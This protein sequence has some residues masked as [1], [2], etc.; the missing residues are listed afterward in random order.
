MNL[1]EAIVEHEPVVAP[2]LGNILCVI[3]SL[4]GCDDT[5]SCIRSIVDQKQTGFDLLVVD[6][7]SLPGTVENITAAHPSVEVVKL[8]EN[9]GW[10]GGNN[11]GIK[12]ALQRG[13]DWVCLL[14]NDTVF[15]DGEVANW[16]SAIRTAPPCLLHPV[17]HYWDQPE[18]AQITVLGQVNGQPNRK[19]TL[20]HGKII[21]EHAYGACL[22]IPRVIFESVGLLDE[23]L[24]LQLEETDFHRRSMQKGY[25]A[26]CDPMVKIFHKESRSF[27]GVRA[28]IKVYYTIRNS[29]LLIEKTP[30]PFKQKLLSLKELYW[31]I[32]QIACKASD[33][34]QLGKMALIRW[35][36]SHAPSATAV[37][38]GT[39]DYMLRRFGRISARRHLQIK[40][41]EAKAAGRTYTANAA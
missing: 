12:L 41:M 7:N 26:A 19:S 4:N 34:E 14:N 2:G 31:T 30:A 5:I 10:A 28:P 8:S 40:T 37:R 36:I 25:R 22:A 32:A 35:M 11:F 17:I 23:R 18:E 9:L 20:W 1:A 6:N 24:F 13:Y 15:P 29:L 33:A 21:M 3:L 16:I 27:G 38:G 39:A